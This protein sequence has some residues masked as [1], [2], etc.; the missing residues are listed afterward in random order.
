[1][2][3]KVP[4]DEIKKRIDRIQK[5]LQKKEIDAL[6]IAQRVD[7]FYFS[8]TAQNGYLY[9]PAEGPPLLMIKKYFPRAKEESSIED[10]L[11][12]RSVKSVPRYISQFYGRIPKRIGME[13]DVMPVR[14][15]LF[16]DRQ[17]FPD[18]ECVDASDLIHSVRM[19]KSDWEI[20]QME[21]AAELS[22]KTFQF[23]QEN[24]R[25]G[26]T[27]M[28]FAG[29]VETFSRR[30]GHG[31]QL[32]VRDYKT[33]AYPWH[34]LSG[35][36]G[37]KIGLLDAPTSGEGT[38][39][40]FPCGAGHKEIREGEPIMIDFGTMLNGF[41]FDETRMFAIKG[42]PKKA[43]DASKAA[44]EIQFK[45]LEKVKPGQTLDELVQI[46][47]AHAY[48]LGYIDYFLG[49][50]KYK[51]SFIGH[52]IG[53][54]L[55]EKPIIAM[56][57]DEELRPGM[58]FALE[59]KMVFKDEFAAGIESVFLVTENGYRLLSKTPSEVFIV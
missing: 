15:F 33:E 2:G 44:I 27:E 48:R 49:P 57:K 18:Q 42:M 47:L 56:G 46:S 29:I 8:G 35:E 36:S 23:I 38:S 20:E 1:M 7:L 43:L 59:P 6:F 51:V 28:E 58:V 32:R 12:I 54:E 14:E 55:I 17:I 11:E 9:I 25:P 10:I 16:Y 53:H 30:H 34:I 37:G 50:P 41:H 39:P 22:Y 31:G 21:K 52:G 19:I 13:F 40:A 24:L 26:Y 3:F 4:K 5:E 45:V